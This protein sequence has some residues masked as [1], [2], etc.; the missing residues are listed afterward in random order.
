MNYRMMCVVM[1]S[2]ALAACQGPAGA[3]GAAG[4]AGETGPQGEQGV[5]GDNGAD[6]QDLAAPEAAIASVA[7]NALLVGRTTTLRIVGYFT[8]WDET[9]TVRLTDADNNDVEGVEIETVLVSAVG[10]VANVTVADSVAL[11]ALKLHVFTGET[12]QVYMPEGAS[13][14]VTATATSSQSE[15]QAGETFD[16][17]LETAEYMA[18]PTLSVENCAGVRSAAIGR[19]SQYKFRVTGFMHPAT[20]LGDCAMVLTQDP[21][22]DDAWS[23]AVVVTITAPDVTTFTEGAATGQLTAERNF[24]TVAVPAG[25]GEVVSLRHTL[26]EANNLDGTGA[27]IYVFVEGN[28]EA[29][30]V[31]EGGDRW[32]E[33]ASVEARELLVVVQDA[34][35]EEGDDPVTFNLTQVTPNTTMTALQDG[36]TQDQRLPANDAG[37]NEAGRGSWYTITNEGPVWTTLTIAP[38]DD[39]TFQSSFAVIKDDVVVDTGETTWEGVLEAGTYILAVLDDEQGEEDGVL[40]FGVELNRTTLLQADENGAASGTL[41]T[42]T[43][44]MMLINA[45]AGYVN[46]ISVTRDGDGDAPTVSA[47][48]A[49]AEAPVASAAGMLHVPSATGGQLVV[50]ISLDGDLGEGVGFNVSTSSTEALALDLAG[51]EGAAPETG[52]QWFIGNAIGATTLT[53]APGTADHLQTQLAVYS[54]DGAP[55]TEGEGNTIEAGEILGAFF[56]SVADNTFVAD[57]DQTFTLSGV[58]IPAGYEACFDSLSLLDTT[59]N[60]S[61]SW[62]QEGTFANAIPTG[63]ST[64]EMVPYL[65][66]V[67]APMILDTFIGSNY[68]SRLVILSG[69]STTGFYTWQSETLIRH[70]DDGS[71]WNG[72]GLGVNAGINSV[73]LD[74]G[75]Y[76]IGV[77]HYSRSGVPAATAFTLNYRLR[78]QP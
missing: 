33:V 28:Y 72:R 13:V 9:T 49:G 29:I 39:T 11:G 38:A 64:Y 16:I 55:L 51:T 8:E 69:C 58:S 73:P 34:E 31:Y 35:L 56:V 7:P 36:A 74:P 78:P 62:S 2:G 47:Q 66:T 44:V 37:A 45:E 53:V 5:T 26:D 71:D 1:L 15:L 70:N 65:I 19:Y 54:A 3:D 77:S 63:Y 40:S 68:D 67:G 4:P 6:G 57:Q 22:T 60:E 41:Q 21:D 30:A 14:T 10:L 52:A 25:A 48:W 42:D 18:S 43:E 59:P 76:L 17:L 75:S 24:R 32:L 23:S 27:D 61:M 50:R 46:H 12:S 20:T